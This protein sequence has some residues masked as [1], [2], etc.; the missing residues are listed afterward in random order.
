M[1]KM[2][3]VIRQMNKEGMPCFILNV[4]R[5]KIQT[6]FVQMEADNAENDNMSLERFKQIFFATVKCPITESTFNDL[7]KVVGDDKQEVLQFDRFNRLCDLFFFIPGKVYKQK[8]D[9]ENLYLIM[10]ACARKK[11]AILCDDY[12][13]KKMDKQELLVEKFWQKLTL[14][15]KKIADMFRFFDRNFDN[16]ISY[17]E[18]RVVCEELDLRFNE[19]QLKDLFDWI[20]NERKGA[21]GYHEFMRISDE[22]RLGIDPFD[23]RI[24]LENFDNDR[25]LNATSKNKNK[26]EDVMQIF[27]QR[28]KL[29]DL[30]KTKGKDSQPVLDE[31][32]NI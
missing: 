16:S 18:F 20:D 31:K 25:L 12:K 27:E 24:K 29:F 28:K 19:T 7:L 17:K 8:N 5:K 11:A 3:L 23:N 21:I 14:K 4:L 30:N 9:S 22:K 13:T 1:Q 32:Q 10:S 26:I 6:E 15:F 2:A